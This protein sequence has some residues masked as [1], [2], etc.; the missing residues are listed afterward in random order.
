[1]HA[2]RFLSILLLSFLVL[3][4]PVPLTA[5][6]LVL[7]P[8]LEDTLQCPTSIGRFYHP[9]NTSQ[10][11]I[12]QW[13]ATTLA[14]PDLHHTCGYDNYQPHSGEGYAGIIYYDPTGYREYITAL[15]SEPLEA[16]VCYYVE[17]Y[18]ARNAGSIMA[19][20]EIQVHF[21]AGVPLS[22]QFPPPG[23]LA[24]TPHLE[25][26]TAATQATY[27]KIY[28]LYT[29]S[30]GETAMT[31]GNF[32]D[33]DNTTLTQVGSVGGVMAY[34]YLDDVTVTRLDL[35]PDLELCGVDEVLV[36]PNVQCPAL[37]YAWSNGDTG[38]TSLADEPGPLWLELSGNGTCTAVDT[39]EIL[40]GSGSN[41]GPDLSPVQCAST[42]PNSLY[43]LLEPGTDLGGN[44]L[45]QNEPVDASLLTTAGTYAVQYV[46]P[47]EPPC[48]D[49]MATLTITV[50]APPQPGSSIS[51]MICEEHEPLPLI[52][53]LGNADAGGTWTGP[54]GG[55]HSGVL[56][57]GSDASGV[58][59][60]YV[61]GEAPCP[62]AQASVSVTIEPCV[63]LEEQSTSPQGI[64]WLGQQL[65]GLHSFQRTDAQGQPWTAAVLDATGRAIQA[66]LSWSGTTLLLDL[67]GQAS[68]AY[69]LRV[70]LGDG[71]A[72]LRFMHVD[73]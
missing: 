27:Q 47:G 45:Y 64:H 17:Y 26:A 32:M 54:S 23:P 12:A 36:V 38:L 53:L 42:P 2:T 6:N 20:N 30:G 31:F 24:L 35:G 21:S 68:G 60:Y 65:G 19:I 61:Q 62:D 28:G 11:Y 3:A 70:Q 25:A 48:G 58:Y 69:L 57:P 18:V 15:L 9:T 71:V 7:D 22:M 55:V 39:V 14:S 13:R 44:F 56:D 33:N 50:H 37:D 41:A 5:Q 4:G 63:G 34:Y 73:R 43:D 51:W 8:G 72:V 1:M 59:T 29:A 16:G 66:P 67:G 52:L 10:Q 49:D 40:L 46:V